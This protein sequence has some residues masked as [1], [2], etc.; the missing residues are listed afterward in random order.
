MDLAHLSASNAQGPNGDDDASNAEAL[1]VQ[2]QVAPMIQ[3]IYGVVLK[4]DIE[5]YY[6]YRRS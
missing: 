1:Y 4:S 6:Q 2:R 5:N 3:R